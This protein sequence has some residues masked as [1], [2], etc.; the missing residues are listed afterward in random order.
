[1]GGDVPGLHALPWKREPG[2]DAAGDQRR[3]AGAAQL[4]PRTRVRTHVSV[5]ASHPGGEAQLQD[6]PG[7]AGIL[8]AGENRR[9]VD[10]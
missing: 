5:L 8:H 6:H 7:E 9:C 10:N 1:M 3:E 4:L 2:G